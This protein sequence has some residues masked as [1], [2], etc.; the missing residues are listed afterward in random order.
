MLMEARGID[1][2]YV[3]ESGDPQFSVHTSVTIPLLRPAGATW[4][5]VWE[6]WLDK[7]KIFRMDLRRMHGIS[8]RKELH[9]QVLASGGGR[10]GRN[11]QQLGKHGGA[12]IYRWILTQLDRFLPPSSIITV[13]ARAGEGGRRRV[14][15]SDQAE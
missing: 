13:T 7:Y 1:V 2:F 10:Y 3:D 11:G 15:G 5:L 4:Q 8:V 6:D 14:G 12:A 9:A